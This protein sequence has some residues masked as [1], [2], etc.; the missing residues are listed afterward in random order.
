VVGADEAVAPASGLD[1][2]VL[3]RH[4]AALE[5][6]EALAARADAHETAAR[7]A[8]TRALYARDWAHFTGW[9]DL[10]GHPPL[11]AGADTVRW[12]L[13]DLEAA[14]D[15][16]G[17]QLYQPATLARRLAAIAAAHRD[18]GHLSATR[19]PRVRAVLSGI[20]RTRR[21][22]PRRMRP[23]LLDDL[24]AILA[25]M[26]FRT[27]PAGVAATRDSFALLA[28]FAG[29]LRRS[30]L[31]ALSAADITWHHLD[32]L[33]V[34]IRASKTDQEGHG[35]TVV[36]PFGEHP[37]TCPPCAWLRWATLLTAARTGRSALM[38]AVLATPAWPDWTHL[39]GHAPETTEELPDGPVDPVAVLAAL[40]AD[41]PAVCAIRKGGA[42]THGPITG[43][44]LHAM[45]KRRAHAANLTGPVGFHSLRAGFVTQARRAGADTRSVRRQTRHSSDHMVE[46]YDRDHAPLLGNAVTELGL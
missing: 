24:R 13:T 34:R 20:T 42:L 41:T 15:E 4:A 29:A 11:P 43:D 3:G 46:L 37:G 39:C 26:Q 23:L 5:A 25:A 10:V 32:G 1:V 22:P 2:V 44:G 12:Y 45:V 38:S 8:R 30:E 33:H 31:A 16:H 18:A 19:D 27:W 35:A 36:L 40:P 21:H 17:A 14:R 6:R 7:S 28:G 9:C